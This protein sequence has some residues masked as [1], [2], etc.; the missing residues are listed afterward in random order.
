MKNHDS[1]TTDDQ[2]NRNRTMNTNR[3]R[4]QPLSDSSSSNGPSKKRTERIRGKEALDI[5][6]TYHARYRTRSSGKKVY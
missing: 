5:L 3:F 6:E 4:R 1:I 2:S